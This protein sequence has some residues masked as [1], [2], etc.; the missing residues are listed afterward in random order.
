MKGDG[1]DNMASFLIAL[2]VAVL[3]CAFVLAWVLA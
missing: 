1:G 2:S 3:A